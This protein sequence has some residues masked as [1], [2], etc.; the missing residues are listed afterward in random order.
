[1][2]RLRPCGLIH[3]KLIAL[4]AFHLLGSASERSGSCP[5]VPAQLALAGLVIKVTY[6]RR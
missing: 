3:A 1:M 2:P 6:F 5:L 4:G